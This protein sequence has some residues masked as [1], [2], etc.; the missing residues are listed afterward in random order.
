M[1]LYPPPPHSCEC[2]PSSLESW[3][4]IAFV[5]LWEKKLEVERGGCGYGGVGAILR[6]PSSYYPS[7]L[8]H[9][10]ASPTM[11]LPLP[12][13]PWPLPTDTP[14]RVQRGGHPPP[15]CTQGVFINWDIWCAAASWV[16]VGFSFGVS[17]RCVLFLHERREC[18]S[19]RFLS[20]VVGVWPRPVTFGSSIL[21]RSSICSLSLFLFKG[22]QEEVSCLNVHVY[23]CIVFFCVCVLL[24]CIVRSGM[25]GL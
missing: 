9:S 12:L 14:I 23:V 17:V 10:K 5:M 24:G 22:R 2:S 19:D 8:I 7:S 16:V 11:T 15:L 4:R 1:A 20:D 13:P 21:G 25:G 3:S 18:Q 6:T